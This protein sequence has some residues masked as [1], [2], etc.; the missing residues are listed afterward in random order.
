MKKFYMLRVSGGPV[1]P[2]R[3]K[4]NLKKA[5]EVAFKMAEFHQKP[6][7]ILQSIS[8]VEVVDGKP[9]WTDQTPER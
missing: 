6:V 7:T 8:S 9:V 5:M 3:K 1:E 2:R 4:S